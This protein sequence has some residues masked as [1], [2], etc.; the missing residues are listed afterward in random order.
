MKRGITH[1]QVGETID[2]YLLIKNVKKGTA[3]NGNPFLS[4]ILSDK[5]GEIE[6]KL[7]SITSEDE[8]TFVSSKIVH[9]QG[10]I[11]EFRGTK[12]L[13]IKTMRLATA[14]DQVKP[15]DFLQAAPID[16]EE[17]MARITQYIFEMQNPKIQRITRHLL[18]KHQSTFMQ[19]PA[20]VS[21]FL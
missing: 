10:D 9:V 14:M 2:M 21:C 11:Q 12:Q 8:V 13:R 18:K 7:W 16:P 4:L 1:Y 19:V 3:S 5:T 20:V 17:M 15:S 6:A